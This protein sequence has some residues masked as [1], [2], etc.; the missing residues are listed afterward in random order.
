[1]GFEFGDGTDLL[2]NIDHAER[3]PHVGPSSADLY[4]VVRIDEKGAFQLPSGKVR[5]TNLTQRASPV[6]EDKTNPVFDHEMLLDLPGSWVPDPKGGKIAMRANWYAHVEVVENDDKLD[7]EVPIMEGFLSLTE[8]LSDLATNDMHKSEPVITRSRIDALRWGSYTD[9]RTREPPARDIEKDVELVAV[10]SMRKGAQPEK[11]VGELTDVQ[12]K[13]SAVVTDDM[14]LS[15]SL[16]SQ[17]PPAALTPS[18]VAT[19]IN[20]HPT[21][22]GSTNPDSA[23]LNTIGSPTPDFPAQSEGMPNSSLRLRFK[24]VSRWDGIGRDLAKPLARS[25]PKASPVTCMMVLSTRLFAGYENGNIF[26]WDVSG[27]SSVPLHQFEAHRVPIS[28]ISYLQQGDVV[29]TTGLPRSQEEPDT[30]S[31]M[32]T[33]SAATL[34]LQQT[35]YL[36]A[37]ATRNLIALNQDSQRNNMPCLALATETRQSKLIQMMRYKL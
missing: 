13:A 3:L 19:A 32:R 2:V 28:G 15:G 12:P 14:N 21:F 16:I 36:K 4:C 1:M 23:G 7:K 11:A 18:T 22:P 29:V 25:M 24:V 31:V 34:Q 10:G 20:P 6:N 9:T 37:D 26:I 33:W 8:L 5:S 27:S 35:I 17:A 30:D